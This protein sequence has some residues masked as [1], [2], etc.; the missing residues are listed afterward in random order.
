MAIPR[1]QNSVNKSR[2]VIP[3]YRQHGNHHLLLRQ[4]AAHK[5]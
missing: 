1:V 2:T 5:H 4:K 3:Q